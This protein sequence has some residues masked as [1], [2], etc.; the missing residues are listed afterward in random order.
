MVQIRIATRR[1]SDERLRMMR[2]QLRAVGGMPLSVRA[3]S[4]ELKRRG[5][6]C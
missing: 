3:V 6:F 5:Y 2:D 1:L 4:A